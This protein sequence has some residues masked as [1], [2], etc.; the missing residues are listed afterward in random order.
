MVSCHSSGTHHSLNSQGPELCQTP[1]SSSS[2][3]SSSSQPAHSSLPPTPIPCQSNP[4]ASSQSGLVS[5]PSLMRQESSLDELLSSSP[6]G[7][8]HTS[9]PAPII[10]PKVLTDQEKQQQ[11]EEAMK[12]GAIVEAVKD[13]YGNSSV[14]NK[15]VS[16]VEAF[17][18]F[19]D[20]LSITILGVSR[21]DTVWKVGA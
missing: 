3:S 5:G 13:P 2:S 15:F 1:S 18:K 19:V 11:K 12:K 8:K 6:E 4:P 9:I 21:L 14:L 10:T 17:G 20:D 7:S 16:D